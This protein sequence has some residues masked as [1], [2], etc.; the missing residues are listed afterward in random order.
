[1][2]TVRERAIKEMYTAMLQAY[3]ESVRPFAMSD[4]NTEDLWKAGMSAL[5]GLVGEIVVVHCTDKSQVEPVIKQLAKN[6]QLVAMDRYDEL[7]SHLDLLSK[8]KQARE[9]N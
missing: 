5:A 7:T 4:M 1:M 8:L 2:M 3:R 9:N 6:S